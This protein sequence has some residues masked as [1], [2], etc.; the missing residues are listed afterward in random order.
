MTPTPTSTPALGLL[1][2]LILSPPTAAAALPSNRSIALETALDRAGS[3]ALT[4]AAGCWLEGEVE[5]VARLTLGSAPRSAGRGA[6]GAVTPE[7]G[8]RWT[9]DPGRWRP[10][11]AVALGVRLPTVGRATTATGLLQ[12]GL[13]RQL[14]GGWA[15]TAAVGLRLRA[16]ERAAWE[17]ALGVR[18]GF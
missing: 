6:T 4:L 8:L 2:A 7:A 12:G 11:L 16:A 14:G 17:A 15:A 10:A 9:P 13:E 1:L 18:L 3:P 5:A